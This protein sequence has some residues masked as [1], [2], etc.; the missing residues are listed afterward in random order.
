MPPAPPAAKLGAIDLNLLVVFDA[1]MQERNVTRAGERLGLSQPAMSHALTRL[2]HMLKDDLF[3]RSPKGMLPTPRAEQL[4]VPVRMALDGLQHSLEPTQFDPSRATRKFRIAIDNYGAVVLVGILAEQVGKVAPQVLLEFVPSGTLK[5]LDLLDNGELDLAIG[6][7]AALAERFSNQVLVQDDFV[8]V[9]RKNHPAAGA[10][11][12]SIEAFA[13]LAH[14]EISSV[15]HSTD[16]VDQALARRKLSR[17]IALHAPF[18]S[19]SRILVTSG[20]TSVLPRRVAEELSLHLPLTIRRLPF[21]SPII[22]ATMIWPRWLDNQPAHL[23]IRRVIS[24]ASEGLRPHRNGRG[25]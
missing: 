22:K 1:V 7:S 12:L 21:P 16:F 3:I 2:R 6:P 10:R 25:K 17:R 14:L 13:A 24:E 23:W 4:A 20:M 9:L 5:L 8:A 11:E 18:L 15:R 19:A